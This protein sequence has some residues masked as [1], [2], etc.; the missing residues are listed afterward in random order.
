[1]KQ[2]QHLRKTERRHPP[3]R[4]MPRVQPGALGATISY[5]TWTN[6]ASIERPRAYMPGDKLVYGRSGSIPRY[7]VRSDFLAELAAIHDN[8]IPDMS[9]R[10][11]PGVGVSDVTILGNGSVWS[12]APVGVVRVAIRPSDQINDDRSWMQVLNDDP[13]F[14]TRPAKPISELADDGW[15][16]HPSHAARELRARLRGLASVQPSDSRARITEANG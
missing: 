4:L 13:E 6:V 14:P 11:V 9:E 7:N 3:L 8:G 2:R 10:E 16:W 15:L 1:M 5:E 12:L